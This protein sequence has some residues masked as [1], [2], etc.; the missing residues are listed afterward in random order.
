MKRRSKALIGLV[1]FALLAHH[2]KLMAVT[3]PFPN[4]SQKAKLMLSGSVIRPSLIEAP[5]GFLS[6]S[7]TEAP[8]VQVDQLTG[9]PRVVTG[10]LWEAPQESQT[11]DQQTILKTAAAFLK[12]HAADFGVAFEDLSLDTQALLIDQ[13]VQFVKYRVLV[14]GAPLVDGSIDLQFKK[15]Q[16]V[17]VINNSFAEATVAQWNSSIPPSVEAAQKIIQRDVVELLVIDTISEKASF[18]RIRQQ[19]TGYEKVRVQRYEVIDQAGSPYLVDLDLERQEVLALIPQRTNY[20]SNQQNQG[21][22]DQNLEPLG[23]GQALG[24]IYPRWY[25]DTIKQV[26]IPKITVNAGSQKVVTDQEGGF[27]TRGNATPTIAGFKGSLVSVKPS[28][29]TLL[30]LEGVLADNRWQITYKKGTERPFA[31]KEMAQTMAYIHTQ[32][33]IDYAGQYIKSPWLQKPFAV[34]VNLGQTCNAYWDGTTTNF[35]SAGGRCANTALISDVIYHEWGHG[36]DDNTGGIEDGAYSEGFGDIMSIIMT[37]SNILGIGFFTDGKPVRDLEPNKVFPKDRGEVHDEGL[38][39]GGTFWDLYKSLTTKYDA[40]KAT[41]LISQYA[42]KS[43]FTASRYTDV[44]KAV[45]VIDDNDQDPTN[46]SP[47]FCEINQAFTEHGL[48]KKSPDCTADTT[49][50]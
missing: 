43:V 15:G 28:T 40:A 8:L 1:P 30:N 47:N 9:S 6:S 41:D 19:P 33:I 38:I 44:Y 2:S 17:Q 13:D 26:G 37:Q 35:F 36:L 31:D 25:R 10:R 16:L 46:G 21:E 5:L 49:K 27:T 34:N 12:Q 39:I 4:L 45:L 11:V 7:F 50:I 24:D 22:A 14:D 48:A 32:K 3:Q 20:S 18:W 29:G 42:L 23:R